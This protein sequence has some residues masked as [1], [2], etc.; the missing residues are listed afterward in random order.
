MHFSFLEFINYRNIKHQELAC[1]PGLNILY[2]ENAQGKTNSIEAIYS[3]ARGKNFRGQ[4]D[5]DLIYF[6]EK[7]YQTKILFHTG[8]R[9]QTLCYRFENKNKEKYHNNYPEKKLS[10]MIGYLRAVLFCPDHLS[11]IKGSPAERREF[12]NIAIGQLYPAYLAIFTEYNRYLDNRNALLKK[13]QKGESID[14]SLLDIYSLKVAEIGAII[15]MYRKRYIENIEELVLDESRKIS[16]K[17]ESI[18]IKYNPCAKAEKEENV[19]DFYLSCFKKHR[20]R[21]IQTGSTLYSIGRDDFS[22]ILNKK[23]VRDFGSQGQ[24]R[25]ALLALKLAEGEISGEISGDY[26]IYLFDD[27]LS[28][29]DESRRKF[30]ERRG[31]ERQ[32]IITTCEKPTIKAER[33]IRVQEGIFYKE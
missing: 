26:P 11:I 21:E 13:A 19:K 17:K 32:I 33:I 22:L 29:L 31:E 24:Q 1:V 5:Q 10:G 18:V 6:G 25:S 23:E 20:D 14:F 12:L 15:H 3:F 8:I 27:V 9:D 7:F 30:L 28:E 16:G 2:G 4:K